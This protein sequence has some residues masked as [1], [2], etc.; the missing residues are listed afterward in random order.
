MS[1][2]A[3]SIR[4]TARRQLE[5]DKHT[6]QSRPD[7][8][9]W[10]ATACRPLPAQLQPLAVWIAR[11]LLSTR[12]GMFQARDCSCTAKLPHGSVQTNHLQFPRRQLGSHIDRQR[13]QVPTLV[14]SHSRR[15]AP[16]R[17]YS[18]IRRSLDG[19]SIVLHLLHSDPLDPCIWTFD[20]L[21]LPS[22]IAH[23][24]WPKLWLLQLWHGTTGGS[25]LA[26]RTLGT[27]SLSS[28]ALTNVLWCDP[29][30]FQAA[31]ARKDHQATCM[32]AGT[33][34]QPAKGPSSNDRSLPA[35][36][37]PK[38]TCKET[39]R[40]RCEDPWLLKPKKSAR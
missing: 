24:F 31:E 9:S 38:G 40:L 34:S 35:A 33:S 21:P 14:S 10:S 15:K 8:Q 5:C 12:Q 11:F 19:V 3:G 4:W 6:G 30:R 29:A 20:P 25:K 36:S 16:Q 39:T 7:R 23:W 22:E 13:V 2:F 18:R 27:S 26:W 32:R 28:R 1:L 37:E 17:R